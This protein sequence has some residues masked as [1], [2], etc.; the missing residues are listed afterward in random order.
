MDD[1]FDLV[2]CWMCVFVYLLL[3]VVFGMLWM[4]VC[5]DMCMVMLLVLSFGLV[6]LIM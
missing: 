2:C 1:C 6:S 4:L 5:V 3:V